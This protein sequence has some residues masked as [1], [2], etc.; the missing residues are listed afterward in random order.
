MLASQNKSFSLLQAGPVPFVFWKFENCHYKFALKKGWRD[1]LVLKTFAAPPG[2][3]GWIPSI[4]VSGYNGML[5]QS[6]WI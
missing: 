4:Y 3:L 6:Q 2:D 5:L 1:G